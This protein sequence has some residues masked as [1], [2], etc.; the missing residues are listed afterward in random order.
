MD[1]EKYSSKQQWLK[2]K[3]KNIMAGYFEKKKIMRSLLKPTGLKDE[4]KGEER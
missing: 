4:I 3:F 1:I 2:K